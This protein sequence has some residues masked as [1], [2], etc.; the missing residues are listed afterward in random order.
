[1]SYPQLHYQLAIYVIKYTFFLKKSKNRFYRTQN[2][3][4]IDAHSLSLLSPK[5]ILRKM[6]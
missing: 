6:I 5:V 2:L 1:M 4:K 3:Y